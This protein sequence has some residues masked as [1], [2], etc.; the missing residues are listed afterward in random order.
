VELGNHAAGLLAEM[1]A[2]SVVDD[3]LGYG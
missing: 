2:R 1:A 3:N